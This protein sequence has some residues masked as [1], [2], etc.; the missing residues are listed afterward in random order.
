M[1]LPRVPVRLCRALPGSPRERTG[2][3][4][5]RW[6]P[7]PLTRCGLGGVCLHRRRGGGGCDD[8]CASPAY[9][10]AGHLRSALQLALPP[11]ITPVLHYLLM[12]PSQV[13]MD[14]RGAR[15]AARRVNARLDRLDRG[16]PLE[17]EQIRHAAHGKGQ[18]AAARRQAVRVHMQLEL[19]SISRAAQAQSPCKHADPTDEVIATVRKLSVGLQCMEYEGGPKCWGSSCGAC[20][21]G[22]PREEHA[23]SRHDTRY[24]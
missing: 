10:G 6:P 12:L 13:L 24:S 2:R 5:P 23:Q 4:R 8:R 14:A 17:N 18:R 7:L 15:D 22:R 19:G 16:V 9:R 20:V 1:A 21:S 11:R 3:P